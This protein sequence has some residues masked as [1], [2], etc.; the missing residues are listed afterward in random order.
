MADRRRLVRY[1]RAG[2]GLSDP[3]TRPP[4]LTYE[5]E[6]LDAG[7]AEVTV[8][9]YRLHTPFVSFNTHIAGTARA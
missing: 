9:R 2:C 4:S 6:Q 5:L 8:E 3:T 1:D 7:F